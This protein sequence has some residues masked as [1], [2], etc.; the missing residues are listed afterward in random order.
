MIHWIRLRVKMS[1]AL[2]RATNLCLRG[3][4]CK[5]C[6]MSI[7]DGASLHPSLSYTSPNLPI[8]ILFYFLFL[9]LCAMLHY[10]YI[11]TATAMH[12]LCYCLLSLLFLL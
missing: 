4:R 8:I 9:N 5:F 12:C 3:T 1:R 11:N 2:L 6:S 10:T 7:D